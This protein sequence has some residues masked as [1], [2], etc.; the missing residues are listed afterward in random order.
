MEKTGRQA[1]AF[2]NMIKSLLSKVSPA[3]KVDWDKI[4]KLRI[5]AQSPKLPKEI[6]NGL[7]N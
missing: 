4:N 6:I 3:E 1:R 2:R 7:K 5:N